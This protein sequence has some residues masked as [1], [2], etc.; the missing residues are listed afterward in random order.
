MGVGGGGGGLRCDQKRGGV[1]RGKKHAHE[2][3]VCH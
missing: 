1:I 2:R 3:V